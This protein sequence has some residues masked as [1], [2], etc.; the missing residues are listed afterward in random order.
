MTKQLPPYLLIRYFNDDAES[1]LIKLP[2]R[3]LALI[4]TEKMKALAYG[5]I[6]GTRLRNHQGI[7]DLSNC[8]KLYFDES[9]DIS[10]RFRLVYKYEPNSLQPEVLVIIAIGKR[11]NYEVYLIAVLRLQNLFD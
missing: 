1:D 4:A 5:N 11:E 2:T 6:R 10:P 9:R 7:G 8:F 3:E